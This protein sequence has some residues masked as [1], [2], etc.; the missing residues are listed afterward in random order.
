[1]VDGGG[2]PGLVGAKTIYEPFMAVAFGVHTMERQQLGQLAEL[3]ITGHWIMFRSA[4]G[5]EITVTRETA[6]ELPK[7]E[8]GAVHTMR[9]EELPAEEPDGWFQDEEARRG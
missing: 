1:M 7:V 6:E 3:V 8:L 5:Q 2:K 4:K 9:I